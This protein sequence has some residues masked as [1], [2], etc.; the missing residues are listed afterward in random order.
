M[1]QKISDIFDDYKN[2]YD[3]ILSKLYPSKNNTGFTERNLTVN[4]SKAYENVIHSKDVVSW[5]EFQFENSF[6]MKNDNHIDCILI[7]DYNKN[8]L[9][10]E[11]KRFNKQ[12]KLKS[13]GYDIDRVYSLYN[14]RKI[15]F[16]NRINNIDDYEIY[17]VI[18]TDVWVNDDCNDFR[19]KINESFVKKELYSNKSPYFNNI[20]GY[21]DYSQ[22]ID[23]TVI[24]NCQA[25]N[26]CKQLFPKDTLYL[27]SIIW[28]LR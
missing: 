1:L 3:N 6:S 25:V 14:N 13:V 16:L 22:Q 9:F 26:R 12:F 19:R 20:Y 2:I 27:M 15:E 8:I 24:Y 28:Q 10:I 11:A 21:K 5:F 18:L 7:D 4:F 17:G 23:K